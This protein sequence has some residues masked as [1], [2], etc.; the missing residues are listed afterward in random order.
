MVSMNQREFKYRFMTTNH[1]LLYHITDK[2]SGKVRMSESSH[3]DLSE[4]CIIVFT[5]ITADPVHLPLSSAH[6]S[7]QHQLC[8][9]AGTSL[10]A[11]VRDIQSFPFQMSIPHCYRDISVR[12]IGAD[13]GSIPT[14]LPHHPPPTHFPLPAP[15]VWCS[16]GGG[17]WR[18]KKESN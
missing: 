17:R 16:M 2:L 1:K 4:R 9:S 10:L 8:H 12:I 13:S 3:W 11:T 14:P 5:L 18:H 7:S 6:W 15:C